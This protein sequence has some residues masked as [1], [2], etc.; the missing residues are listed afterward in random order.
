MVV[1]ATLAVAQATHRDGVSYLGLG[2][3]PTPSLG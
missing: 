1:E 2:I 3:Q